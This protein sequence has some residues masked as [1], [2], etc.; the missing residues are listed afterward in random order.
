[1]VKKSK[2]LYIY[3]SYQILEFYKYRITENLQNCNKEISNFQF[4]TNFQGKVLY[5]L[6]FTFFLVYSKV[7]NIR[8]SVENL[9]AIKNN[10]SWKF[11]PELKI[12]NFHILRIFCDS[13]IQYLQNFRVLQKLNL[14]GKLIYEPFDLKGIS[15]QNNL[16]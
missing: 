13:L 10:F 16:I 5:I 8:C 7:M 4:W 14:F 15:S 3:Y 2:N 6:Q 12:A 1:M 11:R 9:G